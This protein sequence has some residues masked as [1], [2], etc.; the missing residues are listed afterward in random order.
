MPDRYILDYRTQE[1]VKNLDTTH[2][3][4]ELYVEVVVTEEPLLMGVHEYRIYDE[5][6]KGYLGYRL[7]AEALRGA[8]LLQYDILEDF[9]RLH[10]VSNFRIESKKLY[11]SKAQFN[12]A[13]QGGVK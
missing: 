3:A 1:I 5:L 10:G 6:S 2:M 4:Q 8:R 13:Y 9:C 12:S 7:T 11:I